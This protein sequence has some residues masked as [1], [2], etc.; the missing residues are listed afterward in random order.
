MDLIFPEDFN[1]SIDIIWFILW[2]DFTDPSTFRDNQWDKNTNLTVS[3]LGLDFIKVT[4]P[5]VNIYL[6]TRQISKFLFI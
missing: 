4:S 2:Q 3:I 5:K 6:L 1:S